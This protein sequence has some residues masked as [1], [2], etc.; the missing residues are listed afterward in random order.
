MDKLTIDDVEPSTFGDDI[1]RRKLA[2]PLNT[3]DVAINRYVLKPGKRLSGLHAHVDQEEVFIVVEGEATFETYA[4]RSGADHADGETVSENGEVTVGED[5]AIRFAPGEFQSEKNDTGE[6]VIL[7]A[8]GAPRDSDDLRIPL[9]CPEC[10]HEGMRLLVIEVRQVL[11]CPDCGAESETTC[12]EC[13][14]NN[15]R[16]VLPENGEKVVGICRDCGGESTG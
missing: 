1:D 7:F 5:E 4:P 13:G 3:T 16:A 11:V 2:D 9:A 15:M 8:L 12:P 14:G 10:S 6:E